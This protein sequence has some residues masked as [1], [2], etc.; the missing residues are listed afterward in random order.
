MLTVREETI[1]GFTWAPEIVSPVPIKWLFSQ[2]QTHLLISCRHKEPCE[3]LWNFSLCTAL[4]STQL[5]PLQLLLFSLLFNF[6]SPCSVSKK[7]PW[8]YKIRQ[9]KGLSHLFPF[10]WGSQSCTDLCPVSKNHSFIFFFPDG[11]VER[12]S[13]QSVSGG[14]ECNLCSRLFYFLLSH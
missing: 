5:P 2:S 14:Q 7:L 3:D 4:T 6:L 9:S 12:N 11:E 13:F 8:K 1:L 10:S